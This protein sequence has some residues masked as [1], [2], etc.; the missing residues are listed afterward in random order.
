[1]R[2]EVGDIVVPNREHWPKFFVSDDS[3]LS[4]G[5]V[6]EVINEIIS[7][8][9]IDYIYRYE[10]ESIVYAAPGSILNLPAV[11]WKKINPKPFVCKSLL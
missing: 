11:C 9:M 4:R 7:V 3:F 10:N 6:V 5:F 2:F 8:K 1:M